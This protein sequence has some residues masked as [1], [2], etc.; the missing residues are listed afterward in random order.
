MSGADIV[1]GMSVVGLM[2]P[3][4]V[5]YAGIAGGNE[6]PFSEFLWADFLRRHVSEDLVEHDFTVA[7]EYALSIARTPKAAYLPGWAGPHTD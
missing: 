4:A 6:T 7:T 3:E 1:A 2:L 5:A